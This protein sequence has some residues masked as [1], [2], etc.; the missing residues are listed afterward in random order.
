MSQS[1]RWISDFT[2]SAPCLTRWSRG[3][4]EHGDGVGWGGMAGNDRGQGSVAMRIIF[5][6]YA[7]EAKGKAN[8]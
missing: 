8:Y 4:G 1:V 5:Y 6:R 3:S 7:T 2:S